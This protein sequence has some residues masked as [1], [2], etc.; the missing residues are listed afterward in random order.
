MSKF[1]YDR[2]NEKN[3]GR[4]IKMTTSWKR[5]IPWTRSFCAFQYMQTLKK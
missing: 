2:K 5:P 3:S 4:S 1:K